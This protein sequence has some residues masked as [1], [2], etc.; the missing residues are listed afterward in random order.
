[1]A[2]GTNWIAIAGYA[3]LI[4]A[5]AAVAVVIFAFQAGVSEAGGLLSSLVSRTCDHQPL[6]CWLPGSRSGLYS[7]DPC[8]VAQMRRGFLFCGVGVER[9]GEKNG[10]ATTNRNATTNDIDS[11]PS[12][13][14][15]SI[16]CANRPKSD[17]V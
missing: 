13:T 4:L 6:R 1:M 10:C 16:C 11:T 9:V 17:P 15:S 7:E 14:R 12:A 5:A 8:L 3:S 2:G